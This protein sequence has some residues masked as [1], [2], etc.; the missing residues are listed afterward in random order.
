MHELPKPNTQA[1]SWFYGEYEKGTLDL[2][3]KYQRNPLWSLGQKC[4]LI[5]SIISGCPLPQVYL[6]IF[7]KGKGPDRKT[8]YEVVDGQQRLR[9][10]I[11]FM[12]DEYAFVQ[13]TANSYPVSETYKPHIGKTY[14]K[15]PED[16]QDTIW[17]FPLAVQELRA[18][19]EKQIRALFRRLNY[20]VE[21]LNQQELRHS[22]YFGE[23][24][25]TVEELSELEF[26]DASHMFTKRDWQRMRDIEFVSELFILVIDG[27]QEQQKTIDKFYAD[28]DV[29]F[30][31]RTHY[32]GIFTRT[33]E[34]LKTIANTVENT[35]FVKKSDFYSLFA[36]VSDVVAKE[37]KTIDLAHIKP[38][39]LHLNRELEKDINDMSGIAKSYY[40]SVIEGANKK[41]K[42]EDRI[43][44]LKSLINL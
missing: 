42:R 23:F 8:I 7:S 34:S 16:M 6:N 13:T 2:S 3:P 20:V 38:Q 43:A 19:D 1:L 17:N 35:R 32:V 18:W 5:D 4:F 22:Q 37:K 36:V 41:S 11:E 31:K 40:Q 39:L 21:K 29:L 33:T 44:I 9:A 27:P 28:Y 24:V 25:K 15:L 26:W 14:S 12:K 10:I 30:P